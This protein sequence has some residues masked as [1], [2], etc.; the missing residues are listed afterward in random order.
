M[1]RWMEIEK[2]EE[3]EE[4]EGWNVVIINNFLGDGKG[5]REKNVGLEVKE[6]ECKASESKPAA[7]PSR[8]QISQQSAPGNCIEEDPPLLG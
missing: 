8:S 1:L 2:D 5:Q 6:F 3:D 4:D 7:L